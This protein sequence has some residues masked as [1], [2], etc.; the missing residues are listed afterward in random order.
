[1]TQIG[2]PGKVRPAPLEGQC[3]EASIFCGPFY[4]PCGLPSTRAVYHR[5]DDT[6]YRMC[7]GC[8]EHRGGEE[9]V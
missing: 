3:E 5:R 7:D 2:T 8:A 4:S 9:I 6:T 1:M